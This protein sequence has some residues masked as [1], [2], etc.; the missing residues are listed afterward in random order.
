[1]AGSDDNAVELV[2]E[3]IDEP[4]D[5]EVDDSLILWMLSLS[6]EQRLWAAQDL[7][8]TAWKLSHGDD[9][10]HSLP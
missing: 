4:S 10:A 7:V 8:D 3:V 5:D 1:M 2:S 9:P 6:C